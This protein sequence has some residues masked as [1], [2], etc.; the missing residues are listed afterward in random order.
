VA[1]LDGVDEIVT[2]FFPRQVR[3]GCTLPPSHALAIA[4]SEGG[5]CS[6]CCGTAPPSTTPASP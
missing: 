6:C 3:L 4:A 2:M 1:A 5:R